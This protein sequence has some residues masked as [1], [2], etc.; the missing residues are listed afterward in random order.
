MTSANLLRDLRLSVQ[1]LDHPALRGSRDPLEL[2][3]AVSW[4]ILTEPGDQFS[5]FIRRS[6]GS[7]A[8]LALLVRGASRSE[9]FG[10]LADLG[11]KDEA[12]E[13]FGNLDE[14]LGD[15]LARWM[16]RLSMSSV[17]NCLDV[18]GRIG[19]KLIDEQHEHWPLQLNDLQLATPSVLWLRGKSE[20]LLSTAKSW[21]VVG[22]RTPT[23]YG[24]DVTTSLVQGLAE[25]DFA[26]VSGGAFGIDAIAHRGA[27]LIETPTV[28]V[29][30]GGIDR[31]YPRSN[32][33]LLQQIISEG[34]VV[35]E[36]AISTAP[37]K[38]RFLQRN[39]IIAALSA[40]TVVV[41]AGIR[42]GA[43]NTANHAMLLGRPIGAVPG[44]VLSAKSQGTN[45][46]IADLKA[47]LVS[48]SKDLIDIYHGGMPHEEDSQG[49]LSPLETRA[50][51]AIGFGEVSREQICTAA[52]LTSGEANGALQQLLMKGAV[53]QRDGSFARA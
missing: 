32:E 43:I 13:L 37:T 18:A 34:A 33:P 4:S 28:A 11:I 12:S 29:M 25:H 46:L 36:V 10:A 35:S 15:S 22:C 6:L 48:G 20:T 1:A 47:V 26:V 24:F 30:A 39:R 5:G 16:P 52:G 3:A 42:S 21:A 40:G 31:L 8:A 19:V 7:S 45:K 51:D 53:F 49:S 17:T 14:T 50:L 2:F 44:S 23:S 9:W 38:W 41:E 27:L